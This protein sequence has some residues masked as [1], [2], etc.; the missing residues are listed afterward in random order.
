M[1]EC[2]KDIGKRVLAIILILSILIPTLPIGQ[3]KSFAATIPATN[4]PNLALTFD[5]EIDAAKYELV[6]SKRQ[7]L[8]VGVW[9]YSGGYWGSY[10]AEKGV[11]RFKIMDYEIPGGDIGKL[12]ELV[13]KKQGGIPL[14]VDYPAEVKQALKEGKKS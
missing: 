8:T 4:N 5:E 14:Y 9:H 12:D 11:Y 2:Y 13:Q 3:I 6:D 7:Y 1:K 10:D